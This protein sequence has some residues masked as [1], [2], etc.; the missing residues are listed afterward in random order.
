M[1]FRVAVLEAQQFLTIWAIEVIDC[2]Y[3]AFA[4]AAEVL[5][6]LH[7]HHSSLISMLHTRVSLFLSIVFVTELYHIG[8]TFKLH[9][10]QS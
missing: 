6:A 2:E 9:F 4:L 5:F 7:L 8:T 10:L 1:C 3:S